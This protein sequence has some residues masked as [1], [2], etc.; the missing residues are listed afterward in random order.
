[1]RLVP[2]RQR[3]SDP[4][5][6]S[7]WTASRDGVLIDLKVAHGDGMNWFVLGIGV[8]DGM[9]KV[10]PATQRMRWVAGCMHG[11]WF[12]VGRADTIRPS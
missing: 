11:V 1:L 2:V 9:G 6:V 12:N 4:E 10:P 5:F 3:R 7:R 8:I